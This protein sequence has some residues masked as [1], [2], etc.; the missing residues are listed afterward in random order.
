[1]R[2]RLRHGSVASTKQPTAQGFT[3]LVEVSQADDL[4]DQAANGH[5]QDELI[6]FLKEQIFQHASRRARCYRLL[7]DLPRGDLVG[8]GLSVSTSKG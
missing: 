2:R 6:A 1:M 5:A 3:W 4:N 8:L 7:L